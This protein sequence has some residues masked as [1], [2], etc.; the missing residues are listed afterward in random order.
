MYVTGTSLQVSGEAI[1]LR[2][3]L[4]AEA[5]KAGDGHLPAHWPEANR[6]STL[7]GSELLPPLQSHLHNNPIPSCHRSSCKQ[8]QSSFRPKATGHMSTQCQRLPGWCA[9]PPACG[10][11]SCPRLPGMQGR[12]TM[13]QQ[14]WASLWCRPLRESSA[15]CH[16][17]PGTEGQVY[18]GSAR[19]YWRNLNRKLPA[20]AHAS[21]VTG[22]AGRQQAPAKLGPHPQEHRPRPSP[23]P[24]FRAA[25]PALL[26][27]LS[28]SV[29]RF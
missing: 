21:S 18:M 9:G 1:L 3:C 8:S 24:V 13:A 28:S 5:L 19:L 15:L 20:S 27:T 25:C 11:C 7:F 10:F 22:G 17:G 4:L 6:V 12:H 26:S 29:T 16:T 14:A 2:H 23:S